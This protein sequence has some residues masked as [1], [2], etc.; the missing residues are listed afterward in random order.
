[1]NNKWSWSIL[2]TINLLEYPS[3]APA[4]PVTAP[5]QK[6]SHGHISVRYALPWEFF[7][8]WGGGGGSSQVRERYWYSPLLEKFV[9]SLSQLSVSTSFGLNLVIRKETKAGKDLVAPMIC[10]I[11]Q[12]RAL[13]T[14]TILPR[15]SSRVTSS[16]TKFDLE[17]NNKHIHS[18]Y[19]QYTP[20]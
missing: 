11:T 9:I 15:R 12:R 20:G 1:M 17:K 18:K 2:T 14:A 3:P 8:T 13:P 5:S 7:P 4:P 16:T 6:P 19:T 10:R